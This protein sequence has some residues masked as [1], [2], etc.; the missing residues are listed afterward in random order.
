MIQRW[1]VYVRV[2]AP[3]AGRLRWITP[4]NMPEKKWRPFITTAMS[5]AKQL[6]IRPAKLKTT[7]VSTLLTSDSYGGSGQQDAIV[8]MGDP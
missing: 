2:R 1:I 8:T 5:A 4:H 7:A 6:A 3:L